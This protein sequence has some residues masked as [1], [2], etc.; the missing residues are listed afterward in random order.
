MLSFRKHLCNRRFKNNGLCVKGQLSDKHGFSGERLNQQ[1]AWVW[2]WRSQ[3]LTG[4][5]LNVRKGGPERDSKG[6]KLA[7]TG[8]IGAQLRAHDGRACTRVRGPGLTCEQ[9]GRGGRARRHEAMHI[10][11]QII[12]RSI[13]KL[14]CCLLSEIVSYSIICSNKWTLINAKLRWNYILYPHEY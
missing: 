3:A 13:L 12:I 10:I 2:Q 6:F 14:H 8:L 4:T 11:I 5:S 9:G 1:F 7:S